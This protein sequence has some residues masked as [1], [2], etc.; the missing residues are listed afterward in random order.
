MS[1]VI[2]ST[3]E[4]KINAERPLTSR[5]LLSSDRETFKQINVCVAH[6]KSESQK[7]GTEERTNHSIQREK[8]EKVPPVQI[9]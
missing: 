9:L 8:K 6:A 5:N 2:F 1:H 3:I 4:T 7:E